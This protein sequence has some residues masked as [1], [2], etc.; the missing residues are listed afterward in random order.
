MEVAEVEQQDHKV[1][2]VPVE[3]DLLELAPPAQVQQLIL[4]QAVAVAAVAQAPLL[5]VMA[6][7]DTCI[8]YTKYM[9]LLLKF[10]VKNYI[11]NVICKLSVSSFLLGDKYEFS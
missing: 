2:V 6:A 1:L 10:R 8:S 4:V 9:I 7:R 11:N 5:A 3:M